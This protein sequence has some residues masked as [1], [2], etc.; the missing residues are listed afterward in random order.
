MRQLFYDTIW[1][2]PRPRST[3]NHGITSTFVRE[4]NR[5]DMHA[6]VIHQ[7]PSVAIIEAVATRADVDETEL[8]P[9]HESV[10]PDALDA[11]VGHWTNGAPRSDGHIRFQYYG[12]TVVLHA[13]G[14]LVIETQ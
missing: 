5:V 2:A 4:E 12:Y 9:L 6:P 11:L 3:D 14:Q 7:L 10:D 13:D 1:R 8:P